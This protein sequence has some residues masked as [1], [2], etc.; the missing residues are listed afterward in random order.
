[1]I[2][3]ESSHS[4]TS[5]HFLTH[6][7]LVERPE[8]DSWVLAVPALFSHSPS[9]SFFADFAAVP[10]NDVL[11]TSRCK[12]GRLGRMLFESW[13]KSQR[14]E[15]K[16]DNGDMLDVSL[17]VFFWIPFSAPWVWSS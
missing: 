5:N 11:F 16:W 12:K 10:D 15:D 13:N 9:Q 14:D 3:S 1:M 4:D 17:A 6:K 8:T 7:R 2:I